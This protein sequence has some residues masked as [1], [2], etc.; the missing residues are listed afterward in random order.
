MGAI[1]SLVRWFNDD[2]TYPRDYVVNDKSWS[3]HTYAALECHCCG[4]LDYNSFMKHTLIH[5]SASFYHKC[6][7]CENH[8]S[9]AYCPIVLEKYKRRRV[10]FECSIHTK[11]ETDED[12]L[13]GF[14]TYRPL[15]CLCC[16]K[17]D[18]EVFKRWYTNEKLVF[19]YHLCDSCKDH[20][21][22]KRCHTSKVMDSCYD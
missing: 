1:Q 19:M 7:S 5:V 3:L 12:H 9:S 16:L 22:D 13:K 14:Y 20:T 21:L 17:P 10:F 2:D 4:E 15:Y 11:K 8:D 18:K 6:D